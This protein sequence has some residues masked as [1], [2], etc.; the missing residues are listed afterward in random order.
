MVGFNSRV[1]G[2]GTIFPGAIYME[3]TKTRGLG[4]HVAMA[5]RQI[6]L[7]GS[8]A[9]STEWSALENIFDDTLKFLEKKTPTAWASCCSSQETLRQFRGFLFR[10]TPIAS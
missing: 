4:S 1:S 2:G 10:E 6:G 8:S 7:A 5:R 3:P 9:E